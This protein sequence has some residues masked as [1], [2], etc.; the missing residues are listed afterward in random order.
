MA[1]SLPAAFLNNFSTSSHS[2]LSI[3]SEG[4]SSG[5]TM[6]SRLTGSSFFSGI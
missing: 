6:S 5:I 1:S 2:G 4:E 3:G